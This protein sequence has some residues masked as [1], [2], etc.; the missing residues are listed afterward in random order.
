MNPLEP[1]FHS[2]DLAALDRLVAGDLPEL[3]RRELLL[4]LDAEP[5]G[6]R[7]CAL[8]FLEDQAWRSALA[9][10]A[11]SVPQPKPIVVPSSNSRKSAWFPRVAVAASILALAF[12]AGFAAG[13]RKL[14]GL[15][16]S[17]ET[18]V[19]SQVPD[20]SKVLDSSQVEE[21]GW[22]DLVDPSAGESPPRRVPIVSGPGLDDNWLRKQAPTISDYVRARWER[23]GY[24]IQERRKLVS[25]TLEDGRRVSIPMDEVAVDYVGQRP[26]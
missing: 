17:T 9:G 7:R 11:G 20:P 25:V 15:V 16:V 3:E 12:S 6:W 24:Q 10:M 8:A 26:L 2:T 19:L 5:D 13:G 1:T 23:Q 21:V 22:V 18:P 14:Q 4:K